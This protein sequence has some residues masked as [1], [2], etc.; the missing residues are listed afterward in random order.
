MS[1]TPYKHLNSMY[2][3]RNTEGYSR[4]S[5]RTLNNLDFPVFRDFK[6]ISLEFQIQLPIFGCNSYNFTYF[7][8]LRRL[9][10]LA[11]KL[12]W[13]FSTIPLFGISKITQ[14]KPIRSTYL[15]CNSI[16]IST[17]YYVKSIRSEDLD[18]IE[19]NF[20]YPGF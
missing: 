10:S 4:K 14:C 3:V 18:Q 1:I 11:C 12:F 16:D 5:Y 15:S 7:M 8:Q 19:K 17:V 13:N 6:K 9:H 2:N 20:Q